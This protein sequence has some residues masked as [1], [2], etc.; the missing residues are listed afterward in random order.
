MSGGSVYRREYYRLRKMSEFSTAIISS[1][2][3]FLPND[4]PPLFDCRAL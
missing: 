3:G 1:A 2:I 4:S